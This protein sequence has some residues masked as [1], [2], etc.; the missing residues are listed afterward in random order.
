MDDFFV[1]TR[2]GE[3]VSFG[4]SDFTLPILYFRDDFFVLYYT[5]NANKIREILPTDNLHPICFPN[6]RAIIAIGAYNYINTS[7][8]P[9]G[10][11]FSSIPCVY[12]KK[13]FPFTGLIPAIMESKYP[14]FGVLV[15][16]LPVTKITARDAGRGVWGYTKFV[17]DMEFLVKPESIECKLSEEDKHIFTIKTIKRGFFTDDRKPIITYSV[18][19]NQLIKTI[20]QQKGVKRI[21]LRTDGCY[22]EFGNHPMADSIQ[23]LDISKAPFMSA[24]YPERYAILPRGEIIESNIQTFEGYKGMDRDAKHIINYSTS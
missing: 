23:N 20:I 21:S 17:A 18:K 22:I 19:D 14:G 16:H 12:G 11:V 6:R 15:Q 7:I 5:A 1:N 10:E 13:P 2:P 8:G 3:E 9:Y 24:Y 4:K